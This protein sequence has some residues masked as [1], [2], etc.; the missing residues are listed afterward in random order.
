[1][2]F[3]D[4]PNDVLNTIYSKVHSMNYKNVLKEIQDYTFQLRETYIRQ[5]D[6]PYSEWS[7]CFWQDA[8][9]RRIHVQFTEQKQKERG[10]YEVVPIY[11]KDR[12]TRVAYVKRPI[13]NPRMNKS[14][15]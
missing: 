12:Y 11:H 8:Y 9:C 5:Q 4:L 6:V 13:V 14:F 15:M 7:F 1:M 3:G 2:L 10:F